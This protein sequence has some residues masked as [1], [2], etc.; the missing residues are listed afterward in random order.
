MVAPA[1]ARAV[2]RTSNSGRTSSHPQ[3]LAP[4]VAPATTCA[5]ASHLQELGQLL[6]KAKCAQVESLAY[7]RRSLSPTTAPA[8]ACRPFRFDKL[9]TALAVGLRSIGRWGL[10][11][12][13]PLQDLGSEGRRPDARPH[14]HRNRCGGRL[15]QILHPGP[16]QNAISRWEPAQE[17]GQRKGELVLGDADVGATAQHFLH[18]QFLVTPARTGGFSSHRLGRPCSRQ[19][20]LAAP[21]RTS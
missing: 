17:A 19:L 9:A 6:R 15:A 20:S 5:L 13:E 11:L 3:Q 7:L 8:M 4:L 10:H 12:L 16:V 21:H 2:G 14:A 18:R 1:P